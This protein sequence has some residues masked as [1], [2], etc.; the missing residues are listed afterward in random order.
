[1]WIVIACMDEWQAVESLGAKL[2]EI[3]AWLEMKLGAPQVLKL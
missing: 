1:M 2:G 3:G